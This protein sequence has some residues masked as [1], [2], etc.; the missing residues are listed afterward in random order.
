MEATAALPR[1][2]TEAT[3]LLLPN[4]TTV[5]DIVSIGSLSAHHKHLLQQQ[6]LQSYP[7]VRHFFPITELNDTEEN[8]HTHLT[9]NQ[10]DEVVQFCQTS[11]RIER[12]INNLSYPF[13]YGISHN[14]FTASQMKRGGSSTGWL[15]AQKR[16]V[17]GL[18]KVIRQY[19]DGKRHHTDQSLSTPDYLILMD[20]DTFVNVDSLMSYLAS[21]NFTN[22]RA[23]I[24][25]GCKIL[26][27][28]HH[29]TSAWGGFA[30]ILNQRAI[31]NFRQPVQCPT[32]SEPDHF[33]CRQVARNLIGEGP[34]FRSGMSVLDLMHAYTFHQPYLNLSHWNKIGFCFHSDWIYSYF[35]NAYGIAPIKA[36]KNDT[37]DALQDSLETFQKSFFWTGTGFRS[38]TCRKNKLAH[39]KLN[40]YTICHQISAEGFK[41]ILKRK[42]QNINSSSV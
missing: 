31:Q 10:A 34:L 38:G 30:T 2:S 17:D 26:W 4:H 39:C 36:N 8:C 40:S 25:V 16:P 28:V 21:N 5:V 33:V 29:F 37:N 1:S 20:D 7:S 42:I 15:C 32:D 22:Q 27:P 12:G 9:Q 24:L 35:L 19:D 3:A 23:R 41:T 18:L 13:L 14:F 11:A 6:V